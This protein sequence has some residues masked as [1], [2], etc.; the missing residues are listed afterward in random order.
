MVTMNERNASD[1]REEKIKKFWEMKAQKYPLPLEKGDDLKATESIIAVVKKRGVVLSGKSILDIGCGTGTFALPLARE[2][3]WVKGLDISEFM[4]AMFKKAITKHGIRNVEALQASWRDLDISVQGFE[5]A[6]DIVWTAM[7]MAVLGKDD[8]VK[9]ELCAKDWCVYVGWGNKR[10]NALMEEV[11]KA[12]GMALRPP[13]GT[14]MVF[15][16]LSKMDREPSI[17]FIETSWQ[18]QG[19]VDE[20]LE[21]I[22]GHIEM[23]RYGKAP[24]RKIIRDIIKSYAQDDSVRHTT[25]VEEG[26]IVWRS[27]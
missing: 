26:I 17:D 3:A 19:S 14:K 16:F 7:S 24:D 12:H 8:L 18:W 6:F 2:A 22:A 25:Y 20:A 9:M 15:E 27:R 4:L 5:K 11:F 13:P 1:A 23:E 21:D 10:E